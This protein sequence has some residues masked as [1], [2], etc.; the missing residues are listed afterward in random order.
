MSNYP[1]PPGDEHHSGGCSSILRSILRSILSGREVNVGVVA[2][3]R[4]ETDTSTHAPREEVPEGDLH[5]AREQEKGEDGESEGHQD[6]ALAWG[7]SQVAGQ[8]RR[9][10]RQHRRL[11]QL[12]GIA[13]GL[14]GILCNIIPTGLILNAVG[15]PGWVPDGMVRDG[16][17]DQLGGALAGSY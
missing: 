12:D 5:E 8:R 9:Q 16:C 11:A 6:P 1:R 2:R 14:G 4:A 10:P 13:N 17:S 7:R 3:V 15:A